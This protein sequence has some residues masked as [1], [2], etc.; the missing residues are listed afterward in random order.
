[1]T[2]RKLL[3]LITIPSISSEPD[4]RKG[5]EQAA[6]WLKNELT[7]IGLPAEIVPTSGHPLVLARSGASA[8]G[9]PKLLF[10]GHYDVQP[11]GDPEQ[12]THATFEPLVREEEGLHRFYGR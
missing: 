11:V 2:V 8:G 3:E 10:Y 4:G 7:S 1:T 9:G 12:W 6:A 5:I